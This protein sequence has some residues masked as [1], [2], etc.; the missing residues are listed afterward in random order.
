M[1][2]EKSHDGVVNK[3]G[4]AGSA[5][6]DLAAKV[7]K[8]VK[9]DLGDDQGEGIA[10]L[11]ADASEAVDSVK[12]AATRDEYMKAG[13]DIAHDAGG[14]LKGVA[15]SVKSVVSEEGGATKS[16]L[17][18]AVES[19]RDKFDEAVDSVRAKR[20]AK[21]AANDEGS[22]LDTTKDDIIDGEV[23]PE[24]GETDTTS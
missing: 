12:K 10:K 21:K 15:D 13:K 24:P 11:R 23:V 18:S 8:K 1:S 14:F 2:E 5:I 19:S 20:E 4:E 16:A 6:G 7:T 17:A 3:W 9:H 22:S